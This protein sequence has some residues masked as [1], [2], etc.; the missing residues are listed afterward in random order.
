[1]D[2]YEDVLEGN[3][4]E[5]ASKT[6]VTGWMS[7]V[8]DVGFER[9]SLELIPQL[10]RSIRTGDVHELMLTDEPNVRPS[11][12]VDRC[13]VLGFVVFEAGGVVAVDDEVLVDG[14]V[15]GTVGGFDG[16]HAP[17]HYNV[18]IEGDRSDTGV[19]LGIELRDRVEFV[20]R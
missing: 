17:N 2:P 8:M 6:P 3:P 7:A 1:M 12:S 14:R 10:S 18:L 16:T 9:R 15:L 5:G 20:R 11:E 19:E 4:Y 13:G